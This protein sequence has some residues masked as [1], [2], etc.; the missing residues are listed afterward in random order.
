MTNIDYNIQLK[1]LNMEIEPL[2]SQYK[3]LQNTY[4]QTLNNNNSNKS[5][6]KSSKENIKLI[7]DKLDELNTLISDK[8]NQILS[9]IDN[10]KSKNIPNKSRKDII[11]DVTKLLKEKEEINKLFDKNTSLQNI[12][13]DKALNLKSNYKKYVLLIFIFIKLI[14]IIIRSKYNFSITILEEIFSIIIC[15]IIIYY[16]ISKF[17]YK[18][19]L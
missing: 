3:N 13:K 9:F 4:I 10:N 1:N 15:L 18:K 7:I 19:F 2:I 6:N 17:I 16:I 8:F 12:K 14:L 11:N 5:S